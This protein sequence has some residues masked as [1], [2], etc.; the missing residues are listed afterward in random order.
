[1]KKGEVGCGA[2]LTQGGSRFAPLRWAATIR[3]PLRGKGAYLRQTAAPSSSSF[4]SSSSKKPGQIED[5]D[6]NEDE[7]D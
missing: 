2:A 1:M 5:E 4:S 3:L 6:E 7:D